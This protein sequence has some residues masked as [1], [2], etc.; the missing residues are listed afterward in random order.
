MS[1]GDQVLITG[2]AGFIGSNLADR[3]ASAGHDILIFDSLV[4]P[5][6]EENLAWL[7]RQHP[8]RI[9]PL[10]GDMRDPAAVSGA[11]ARAR[12]VFHMAAQ[13]AVTTSMNAPRE[14]FEI[15]LLGTMNLLEALRRRAG[16]PP[17]IFASTN[18]VYGDLD[19]IALVRAGETYQPRDA[20]LR[21]HGISEDCRLSFHTPYGC[22]KGAADQYVIDYGR[23]F[24]IPTA[25]L[26]MSCIYGR[27]QRGTE[28]QGWVAHF[29]LR[30]LRDEPITIYGDGRQ[31]R[32]I[33]WVDDAV[34]AYIAT[35]QRIG[36]VRGQ[37]FNLGGGPANAVSLRQVI[38]RIE[39]LLG[40]PAVLRF[41][42]WRPG[43]QRY[44]VADTRRARA[45]LGLRPARDWR[46]GLSLLADCFGRERGALPRVEAAQ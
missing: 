33:L 45:A 31:V 32:D 40:R 12:V 19:N 21:A 20:G 16:P 27:R 37:A 38:A 46:R 11:A 41:E 2:G 28:D 23:S 4:R 24:G 13:V 1:A 36:D 18:K 14:D 44:F 29:L 9:T 8:R 39:E 42:D 17:M 10:L 5:G 7:Q 43:D 3:L 6:V 26:R 34:D 25:V 35:W 30:M 22:S 15:N